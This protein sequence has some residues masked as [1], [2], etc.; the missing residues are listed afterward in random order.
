MK[1]ES[2]KMKVTT[3]DRLAT[4]EEVR[5]AT[6]TSA[7]AVYDLRHTQGNYCEVSFDLGGIIRYP[8]EEL[9]FF[10]LLS[11]SDEGVAN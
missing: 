6:S 3:D 7:E 11:E 10:S 1:H 9:E 5:L 8:A 2:M 4:L